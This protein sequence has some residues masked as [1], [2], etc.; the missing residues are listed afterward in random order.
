[1]DISGGIA[2]S[3]LKLDGVDEGYSNSRDI[4]RYD[5]FAETLDF[6]S[7]NI[8]SGSVAYQSKIRFGDS[9]SVYGKVT[10]AKPLRFEDEKDRLVELQLL[11]LELKENGKVT[12]TCESADKKCALTLT[13]S[14]SSVNRFT[15]KQAE[16]KG[17]ARLVVSVPKHASAVIVLDTKNISWKD[18]EV[19]APFETVWTL[20]RR[21]GTFRIDFMALPGTVVLADS[22]F[23]FDS[24]LL[25]GR[26]LTRDFKSADCR[27]DRAC[28]TIDSQEMPEKICL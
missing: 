23:D 8:A 5:L 28:A 19:K 7:T 11:L 18:L 17:L 21:G 22:V 4:G 27:E 10:K 26:V 6:A 24:A 3:K 15:V 1:M 20:S 9:V 12:R 16:L 13:G 25:L 14:D 2:S